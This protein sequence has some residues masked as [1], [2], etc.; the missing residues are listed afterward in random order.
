[1]I[2]HIQTSDMWAGGLQFWYLYC[3]VLEWC[4]NHLGAHWCEVQFASLGL[5]VSGIQAASLWRVLPFALPLTTC[6]GIILVETSPLGQLFWEACIAKES[7]RA[8]ACLLVSFHQKNTS[9]TTV[10]L[11]M[12]RFS[13]VSRMPLLIPQVS[14]VTEFLLETM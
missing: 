10:A 5:F 2:Q 4:L 6:Q 9:N 1:M 7:Q 11:A 13:P 3:V 8:L 14:Q 12:K